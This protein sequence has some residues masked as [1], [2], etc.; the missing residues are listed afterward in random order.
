MICDQWITNTKKKL[1]LCFFLMR[2]SDREMAVRRCCGRRRFNPLRPYVF[3]YLYDRALPKMQFVYKSSSY[4]MHTISKA[5]AFTLYRNK[6]IFDIKKY[7]HTVYKERAYS[8]KRMLVPKTWQRC[9]TKK[10][11]SIHFFSK[12]SPYGN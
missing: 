8:P 6:I 3:I 11:T 5:A 10:V 12:W 1:S 7:G 9:L 4:S 2:T